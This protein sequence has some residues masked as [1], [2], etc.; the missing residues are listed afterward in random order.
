MW[1]EIDDVIRNEKKK[2]LP[3]AKGNSIYKLSKTAFLNSSFF[4]QPLRT[5]SSCPILT[6]IVKHLITCRIPSEGVYLLKK[7]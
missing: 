7:V 6:D 4:L 5:I 1:D 3:G 2:N